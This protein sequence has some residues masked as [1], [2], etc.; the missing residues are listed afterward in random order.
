MN[1]HLLKKQIK[2]MSAKLD[3]N[4]EK[5]DTE[6][7]YLQVLSR[8]YILVYHVELEKDRAE[9]VKL[10]TNSNVWKME[11]MRSKT[12]FAYTE[13]ITR[14][15]ELYVVEDKQEFCQK[16]NC[17]YILERLQTESRFVFRFKGIPNA[18][19][20]QHYEVQVMRVNPEAFDGRAIVVS[21]G[22]DDVVRE[23]Q[24]NREARD[25]ERRFLE[26][27]CRDYTAVYR[28]NLYEN[29]VEPLKVETETF[30]AK[31]Q[32]F[33]VRKKYC[34]TQQ[35][36]IYCKNYVA[37]IGQEEF[38]NVLSPG[39]L[40][41][42]LQEVSRYV[43]RYQNKPTPAGYVYFEA[44]AIK[45][46]DN[47]E[48]GMIILAFRHIDDVVTLEQKRQFEL[49]ESLERE[50]SQNEV[51]AAL[52]TPY[53]AIFEI[54]VQ[55]YSYRKISCREKIAHYYNDEELSA[56]KMLAQVCKQ[57]VAPKYYYRMIRFFDLNTLVERLKNREFE[58]VECLT[59]EGNWH[60][61]RF[62]VKRRDDEGKVTHVLY[63]TQ[64]IDDEKQYEEHL[65]A[66]AEDAEVANRMKT[67]FISQVA[68]DIRTP[69]N[70]IFG[71]LEIAEEN[72]EDPEKLKYSLEKIRN[73]GEFLKALV[74]DVLDISRME[75]GSM[76]LQTTE[77]D[78]AKLLE[79]IMDSQKNTKKGKQHNFY[80]DIDCNLHPY[81]VADAL[82][83][84]QIYTNVL[85]NAIKYTP[86]DGRI[87]FR[88][89]QDELPG[90]DLVRLVVI[91]SDN[92]I[93]MSEE[94]MEE[95]FTKFKRATDTRIN[96]VTGYGLGLTIVK[97]LVDLMGGT[98]QVESKLGEGS[99]FSI[100]LDF[101][102]VE[103]DGVKAEK[104]EE[105][106]FDCTGMHVL[107]AEDNEMN[108]EVITALLEM[109]GI[110]C[111]CV[112][113]GERCVEHFAVVP[114]GTYDAI[115]MDMQMP[116]M[117]G[118]EA[119]RQIRNLA[120]PW[121]KTIPIYAMTANALKEDV[122]ACLEAGMN[123]HLSKPVNM[124]KLLRLLGNVKK[125]I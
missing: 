14:F 40:L 61:A 21:E 108:R 34:Y 118:V 71:F 65:L 77:I 1:S 4:T 78:C 73:S 79:D 66:K 106:L 67:N 84:K 6:R 36:D 111:K 41:E 10:A 113:D 76:K 3:E 83:L 20:N 120:I 70:S 104:K 38:L 42:R 54:D 124:Q 90:T 69:M 64:I 100:Y 33:Q 30:V 117:N 116:N 23:E 91:I 7:K 62:I 115:L 2:L 17:D 32:G 19:G 102:Y 81:V 51:L 15:A 123:A 22:I 98:I 110:T 12:E 87:E 18:A 97:Q 39:Y 88:A 29:E 119:T 63:V 53:H 114:E 121:A 96:S 125:D 44:Q 75:D 122:Q 52:G 27:L 45:L 49:K 13:H 94:F 95:M 72:I 101:P 57:I 80:V 48:D 56:Q 112:E 11:E 46:Q 82:R 28:V 109:K 107:V 99:S 31:M 59:R 50:K 92:G 35:M 74:N 86:E 16:L 24:R 43:Y 25:A 68:H 105:E 37:E 85:S 93:G 58:E 60:R 8:N 47:L 26:V 89:Y 9:I 5:L 103:S 55:T